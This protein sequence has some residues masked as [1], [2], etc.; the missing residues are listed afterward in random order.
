MITNEIP[1]TFATTH[2]EHFG[3][4]VTGRI[5]IEGIKLTSLEM[6][7]EEMFFRFLQYREFDVSELSLAKYVSMISQGEDWAIA[8]PVFPIRTFRHAAFYVRA[9]GPKTPQE[10]AGARIGVP[11]W[12]ETATV[13]AR[14]ALAHEYGVDLTSIDWTQAGVSEAGRTEKVELKLPPGLRLTHRPDKVLDDMLVAGELDCVIAARVPASYEQGNP[15]I[16]RLFE[17]FIEVESRYYRDTGIYPIMHTVVI[18]RDV[19]DRDP[20]IAMNFL[21][22]FEES[23]RRS[24]AHLSFRGPT[25]YLDPW[26]AEHARQLAV[27]FG[28]DYYPYGI[29]ANRPTLEAFLQYC[30]EQGI[31]HRKLTP[32]E[33]FAEQVHEHFR[34]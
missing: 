15:R 34:V 14:G 2:Y 33:I 25:P 10:L 12:A 9:D 30:D 20:W 5:P 31:T 1:I 11:E 28:E 6:Q 17:N 4:L 18:K 29:E 22:A 32:E 23:K 24:Y 13:F 3:E 19:L 7:T 27:T 16:R 26:A 8:I 21:K